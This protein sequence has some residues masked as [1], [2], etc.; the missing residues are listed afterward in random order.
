ML[1]KR[2][3]LTSL[4]MLQQEAA[5]CFFAIIT[6]IYFKIS[7]ALFLKLYFI[8]FVMFYVATKRLI[9]PHR[10]SSFQRVM[11]RGLHV[12][13]DVITH[14]ATDCSK[15]N[16]RRKERRSVWSQ[17]Q[18]TSYQRPLR[19]QVSTFPI[20]CT[21]LTSMH[22]SWFKCQLVS[23]LTTYLQWDPFTAP[24]AALAAPGLSY[25]VPIYWKKDYLSLR[26]S[27]FEFLFIKISP[28]CT[29]RWTA[30]SFLMST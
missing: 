27:E 4:W 18:R 23:T 26:M 14:G 2:L 29:N 7:S 25:L 13:Y 5:P 9:L 8:F 30:L 11:W 28:R 1:V 6:S 16:M 20:I 3:F 21:L 10:T 17:A 22:F 15:V 24:L 19:A 12:P